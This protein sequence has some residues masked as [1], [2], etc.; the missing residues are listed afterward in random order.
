MVDYT[1]I[2]AKRGGV[3]EYGFGL[4]FFMS[5]VD[6]S[7]QPLRDENGTEVKCMVEVANENDPRN[8][9]NVGDTVAVS[10]RRDKSGWCSVTL[11]QRLEIVGRGQHAEPIETTGVITGRGRLKMYGRQAK[12]FTVIKTASDQELKLMILVRDVDEDEETGYITTSDPVY[13]ISVGDTIHV[14]CSNADAEQSGWCNVRSSDL[15][16]INACGQEQRALEREEW[17]AGKKREREQEKAERAVKRKSAQDKVVDWFVRYTNVSGRAPSGYAIQL[18]M[19]VLDDLVGVG[20]GKGMPMGS[21]GE[22]DLGGG[23]TKPWG[24]REHSLYDK[25]E[26]HRNAAINV[27]LSTGW[28]RTFTKGGNDYYVITDDGK[29]AL[30]AYHRWI[31]SL[32]E[33]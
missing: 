31:E 17:I 7:G 30:V 32:R 24:L 15:E 2:V 1:G 10:C 21:G 6:P 13:K 22:K 4:K 29:T 3:K 8:A 27:L 16:V 25:P 23:W 33:E 9:I 5:L 20:P 26:S 14:R 19:D 12:F 28:A 18:A 11:K